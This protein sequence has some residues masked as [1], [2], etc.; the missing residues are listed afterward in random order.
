[1]CLWIED[2][3]HHSSSIRCLGKLMKEN[4]V[5]SGF[6]KTYLHIK[7]I[8][9]MNAVGEDAKADYNKRFVDQLFTMKSFKP[10]R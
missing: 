10:T 4:Y 7:I 9:Y 6:D 1:M 2:G 5:T 3:C 8:P